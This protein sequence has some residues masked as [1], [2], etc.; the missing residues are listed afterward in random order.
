[1]TRRNPRPTRANRRRGG[2]PKT[3]EGK[4]SS[5]L[6]ALRHGLAAMTHR[7]SAASDETERLAKLLCGDDGD[8]R[9]VS[10]ARVIVENEMLMR[11]IRE[12]ELAVIERLRE[13]TAQALAKGDNGMMLATAKFMQAWLG[14]R[15]IETTAPKLLEKYKDQIAV[16]WVRP[17][18]WPD[19][20]DWERDDGIVPDRLMMLLEESES[21]E[22]HERARDVA[23]KR[24]KAQARDEH[25]ALA[26]ASL[27]LVR[28]ERYYRRAWSRQGRA[29]RHFAALKS[30]RDT[31]Q[32]RDREPSASD[33]IDVPV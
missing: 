13:P 32:R 7:Q 25:D 30:L 3:A 17:D 2:G 12:Q 20:I 21:D 6:N 19:D 4:K 22:D 31:E 27:D 24:L 8:P 26:A 5:S 14:H 33:A 11:A 1:M 10:A 9:L 29:I 16:V 15:E 23:D 18:D 28:L